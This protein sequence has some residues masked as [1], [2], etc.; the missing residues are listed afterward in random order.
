MKVKSGTTQGRNGLGQRGGGQS[1]MTHTY[2]NGILKSI[3][4]ITSKCKAKMYVSNV[5]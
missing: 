4:L 1:I 2:E 5:K 3:C